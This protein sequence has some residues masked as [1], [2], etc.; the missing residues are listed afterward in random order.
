MPCRNRT[1]EMEIQILNTAFPYKVFDR[2][3]IYLPDVTSAC[4]WGNYPAASNC[5]FLQELI[6]KFQNTY[7]TPV[8]MVTDRQLWYKA[9]KDYYGCPEV[10][11]SSLWWFSDQASPNP[12][13]DDYVQIGGWIRPYAKIFAEQTI[14]G[15][16]FQQSYYSDWGE[17]M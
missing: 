15:V 8:S 3:W 13:F 11:S 14:C 10:S 7:N 1:A 16:K 9:F 17:Q 4:G 2:Y 12:N 6:M 5:Q